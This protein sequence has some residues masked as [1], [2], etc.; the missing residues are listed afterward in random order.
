M[1]RREFLVLAGGAAAGW[2]LAARAQQPGRTYRLA[3]VN[4]PGQST[5]LAEAAG[6]RYWRVWRAELQRLGYVEG[7]NLFVERRETEGGARR[8]DELA[9]QIAEIKPDAIFAPAQ[10]MAHA[11]KAVGTTI[12][13]VTLAIDPVESGLVDSL[14]RPGGNITGFSL[15]AGAQIA[16]KRY[17]L[18]KEAVP[19]ISKIAVLI[20]REYWEG[21]FGDVHRDAARQVG[22]TVI[23]APFD[24]AADEREFRRIFAA[25]AGDGADSL[26]LTAQ[27]ELLVNRRLISD[28]AVEMMLPAIGV[29]REYAEA[30]SLMSYA[31]SL[32]DIFRRAAGYIDRILNGA[33]PAEMP[34][35][36]P[37]EFELVINR[38][39]A[40]ALSIAIPASILARADEVIE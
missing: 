34:F 11:L 40:R 31:V 38:K 10:N 2:P 4:R 8:I 35:Q 1:R 9:R 37:N 6:L 19:A 26:Y 30:G 22:I 25:I 23:G 5:D 12:P 33:N 17:A 20:L 7:V 28:L 36:Q 32:D 21:R 29:Y 24:S 3:I 15:S 18:L 39:T 14:A 13:V 16:A 27:A